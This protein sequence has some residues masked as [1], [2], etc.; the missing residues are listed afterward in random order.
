L[1]ATHALFGRTLTPARRQTRCRC[2]QAR[3]EAAPLEGLAKSGSEACLHALRECSAARPP[4]RQAPDAAPPPAPAPGDA[5][6]FQRIAALLERRA[7][8][9]SQPPPGAAAQSGRGVP[10]HA[11]SGAGAEARAPAGGRALAA[12]S[13]GSPG[14]NPTWS[15]LGAAIEAARRRRPAWL[16]EVAQRVSQGIGLGSRASASSLSSALPAGFESYGLESYGC[17]ERARAPGAAR[18]GAAQPAAPGPPHG[19]QGAPPAQPDAGG[20]RAAALAAAAGG[21]AGPSA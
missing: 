5:D 18:G 2:A 19:A 14:G 11:A 1:R 7:S 16:D 21:R 4:A 15:P 17:G 10:G 6:A 20:G 13:A 3:S 9:P 8:A 12:P